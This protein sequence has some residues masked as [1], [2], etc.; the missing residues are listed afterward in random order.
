MYGILVGNLL[1]SSYLEHK[2][3]D[4]MI[5]LKQS[6]R[7]PILVAW[8]RL[9]WSSIMPSGRF[10][11]GRNEFLV[12]NAGYITT[13]MN[14][15]QKVDIQQYLF[16]FSRNAHKFVVRTPEAKRPHGRPNHRWDGNIKWIL[17]KQVVRMRT[18]ES[19]V[20][21]SGELDNE[22]SHIKSRKF[23]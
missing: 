20:V 22:S 19:P 5:I 13:D 1:Q 14:R 7:K 8:A 17:K 6:T 23:E 12:P 2:D 9:N 3:E 16:F 11:S 15:I 4:W 21:G 18:G 10:C